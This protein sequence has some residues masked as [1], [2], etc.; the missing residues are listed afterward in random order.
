MK[1]SL[2]LFGCELEFEFELELELSVSLAT[3]Q[4]S[5]PAKRFSGTCSTM[6]I[7]PNVK[8]SV[9]TKPGSP[10]TPVPTFSATSKAAAALTDSSRSGGV[11]GEE[12]EDS[13]CS[14]SMTFWDNEGT[15]PRRA[16]ESLF[17]EFKKFHHNICCNIVQLAISSPMDQEKLAK[18]LASAGISIN[19]DGTAMSTSNKPMP[20]SM[21]INGATD[22]KGRF[23]SP[24]EFGNAI[25][26]IDDLMNI[27]DDPE[28]TP[29]K[30]KYSARDEIEVIRKVGERAMN[31]AKWLQ[32]AVFST[33][34]TLSLCSCFTKKYASLYAGHRDC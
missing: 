18:A 33:K 10:S 23:Y 25:S 17:V 1:K 24:L 26:H 12:E 20:S 4:S 3:R 14:C 21:A 31:P 9:W 13:M 22:G 19:A 34:L 16:V 8:P 29:Y 5:L 32:M 30:S 6:K 15:E 11:G 28:K 27:S 7:M 2:C